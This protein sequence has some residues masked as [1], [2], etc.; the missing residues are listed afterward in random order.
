[1][2]ARAL[3][4]AQVA[5]SAYVRRLQPAAIGGLLL[6][7]LKVFS[8]TWRAVTFASIV[9]PTIY[10]LAFGLGLRGLVA[11]IGGLDYVQYVSTGIVAVAVLFSSAVPSM[12]NTYVRWQFQRSY[13]ALL[14]APV[15]VE[16]LVTAEVSWI[17]LR[18]G[19][20]A[21]APLA[22]A[23]L[24]GLNPAWEMLLVP[25]A[26]IVTGFGFASFGVT[27]A[28]QAKALDN[29]SYVTSAVITPLSLLAGAFFPPSSLP[30]GI[31]LLAKLNPLYHCVEIVR[32]M[33]VDRLGTADL[34]HA[35]VLLAFAVA[36]WRLAVWRLGARLVE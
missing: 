7:D 3:P 15:D 9:Q 2:S 35:I 18:S 20:Y 32:H 24:F 1:M 5:D 17:A 27:V 22:I 29:F 14:S 36:M 28:A 13:D 34:A 30:A 21:L 26:A 11:E 12:F 25:M 23:M 8:R 33:A 19:I 31:Q 4:P 6:R 10:L 16:E